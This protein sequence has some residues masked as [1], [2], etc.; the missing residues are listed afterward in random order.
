MQVPHG[1]HALELL[2]HLELARLI[3]EGE[4]PLAQQQ[5]EA[6][7]VQG[8]PEDVSHC[9]VMVRMRSDPCPDG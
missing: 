2:L 6:G 8:K 1:P 7:K 9:W 3:E 4:P 5:R